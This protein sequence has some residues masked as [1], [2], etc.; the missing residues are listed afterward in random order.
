VD[1]E[2]PF[3][4]GK[5][6]RGQLD[7]KEARPSPLAPCPQHTAPARVTFRGAQNG[8]QGRPAW[9]R[10]RLAG[11]ALPHDFATQTQLALT[12]QGIARDCK[13][14]H[15]REGQ[16]SGAG[17]GRR[18]GGDRLDLTAMPVAVRISAGRGASIVFAT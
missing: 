7:C 15:A 14:D 1:A 17:K 4:S 9:A 12:S 10:L 3:S 2:G 18:G 16:P 13:A 5:N 6:L 11:D 8:S